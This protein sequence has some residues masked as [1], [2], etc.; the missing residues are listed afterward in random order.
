MVTQIKLRY[1]FADKLFLDVR[2][3]TGN[4][5]FAAI[6]SH[7]LCIFSAE[8]KHALAKRGLSSFPNDKILALTRLKAFADD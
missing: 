6:F 5:V 8:K 3:L 2:M 4:D 7:S 1:T